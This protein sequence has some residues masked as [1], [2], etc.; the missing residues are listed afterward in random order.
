MLIRI[1]IGVIGFML[2]DTAFIMS[3]FII[4]EP[5]ARTHPHYFVMFSLASGYACIISSLI[6]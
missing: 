2:I 6:I 1:I 5:N 3:C 4:N